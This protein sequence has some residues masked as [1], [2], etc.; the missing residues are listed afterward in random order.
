MSK[1]KNVQ[2]NSSWST[3]YSLT[4]PLC[5]ISLGGGVALK[6]P[7]Y[8]TNLKHKKLWIHLQSCSCLFSQSKS[9]SNCNSRDSNAG[10][11]MLWLMGLMSS[12]LPFQLWELV[13]PRPPCWIFF[14]SDSCVVHM[15]FEGIVHWI[16]PKICYHYHK[17]KKKMI[18]NKLPLYD[19]SCNLSACNRIL[20]SWHCPGY[21]T[22][23]SHRQS[24]TSL[25]SQSSIVQSCRLPY[26]V[27]SQSL[28]SRPTAA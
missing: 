12:L 5:Y 7:A 18:S 17:S 27:T 8:E 15:A 6:S 21:G 14:R 19:W 25:L 4:P 28:M 10:S 20:V 22:F 9:C 13:R 11:G 26:I 2:R 16:I 3:S 24:T 23:W 1:L